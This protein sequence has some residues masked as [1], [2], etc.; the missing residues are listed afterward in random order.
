[1]FTHRGPAWF[2]FA[3][4]M[5]TCLNSVFRKAEVTWPNV[6]NSHW[7][8]AVGS[9]CSAPSASGISSSGSCALARNENAPRA[10]ATRRTVGLKDT[11]IMYSSSFESL[12]LILR[13]GKWPKRRET[14]SGWPGQVKRNW[15][16]T[17]NLV[18]RAPH[19]EDGVPV[20][21]HHPA[22]EGEAHVARTVVPAAAP[23]DALFSRRGPP[24]V[25]LR[26]VPEIRCAVSVRAPHPDVPG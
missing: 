14:L 11:F 17:S 8:R 26:R 25:L 13:T 7:R 6:S 5:L 15:I 24:R 19:P 22:A 12:G 9:S 20:R 21:R 18:A 16:R 4:W 2:F 1:M 10:R 23:H 3:L